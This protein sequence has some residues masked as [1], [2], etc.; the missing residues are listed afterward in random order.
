MWSRSSPLKRCD[1]VFS[2]ETNNECL[3]SVIAVL[4]RSCGIVVRG[5]SVMGTTLGNSVIGNTIVRLLEPV[6]MLIIFA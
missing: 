6:A 1:T 4:M 3:V 2:P 5:G